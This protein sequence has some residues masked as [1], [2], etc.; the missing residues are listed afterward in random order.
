MRAMTMRRIIQ[1]CVLCAAGAVAGPNM[2]IGPGP[3]PSGW[4]GKPGTDANTVKLGWKFLDAFNPINAQLF[5]GWQFYPPGSP[6]AWT[7][8]QDYIL[9]ASGKPAQWQNTL[10][11]PQ[12]SDPSMPYTITYVWFSFVY[13]YNKYWANGPGQ[14][15]PIFS[16]V[17]GN[18]PNGSQAYATF[19]PY[20]YA[21]SYY[22]ANG[23][24]LSNTTQLDNAAYACFTQSLMISNDVL[25]SLRFYLG[26]DFYTQNGTV[27]RQGSI[28]QPYVQMLSSFQR[29]PIP[30]LKAK[31]QQQYVVTT[32]GTYTDVVTIAVSCGTFTN[33]AFR[34]TVN[35]SDP[36]LSSPQPYNSAGM[37][38]IDLTN[39]CTLKVRADLAGYA[40]SV[41]S[42]PFVLTVPPPI[43][44]PPSDLEFNVFPVNISCRDNNNNLFKPVSLYY[45]ADGSTPTPSS[46]AITNGQ[47]VMVTTNRVPLK[48][49]ATRPGWTSSDSRSEAYVLM[50]SNVVLNPNSGYFDTGTYINATCATA[51]ATIHYEVGVSPKTPTIS[52]P[53]AVNNKIFVSGSVVVKA[54]GFKS[55]WDEGPETV[56]YYIAGATYTYLASI[57]TPPP[58][59]RADASHP[60][61]LYSRDDG[62]TYLTNGYVIVGGVTN[63]NVTWTNFVTRGIY[64]YYTNVVVAMNPGKLQIDWWDGGTGIVSSLFVVQDG[65]PPGTRAKKLY[66]TEPPSRGPL[67]DVTRVPKLTFFY[68][69][70]I[71]A[72]SN[73]VNPETVW[74]DSSGAKQQL[75]ARSGMGYLVLLYEG[76]VTN[77]PLMGVDVVQVMPN[78]GWRESLVPVGSRMLPHQLVTNPGMPYVSAGINE[79]L[80]YQ[81]TIAGKMN[82][83]VFAIEQNPLAPLA[84]V[85]W[86]EMAGFGF[87]VN[88]PYEMHRYMAYWPD[89]NDKV[90]PA[91]LYVRGDSDDDLGP[92]VLIPDAFNA[93]LMAAEQYAGQYDHG[94]YST[95]TF[96]SSGPGKS[97]LRFAT[98]NGNGQA[99][100]EWVGFEVIKSVER[101]SMLWKYRRVLRLAP[102]TPR[103]N[104]QIRLVLSNNFSYA[105]CKPDGADVRFYDS[106]GGEL[107]YWIE[108]WQTGGV[109]IIWV[110]IADQGSGTVFLEY[111]NAGAMSL[112]SAA[113]TFDFYDNFQGTLDK[114]DVAGSPSLSNQEL[115]VHAG[116]ELIGE[117]PVAPGSII[118]TRIGGAAV[119]PVS[120]T[121]GSL[122]G[123]SSLFEA[124]VPFMS[125]MTPFVTNPVRFA[126]WDI[127]R[128]SS[129]NLAGIC[130]DGAYVSYGPTLGSAPSNT[131]LGV[132]VET[133]R[134]TWFRDGVQQGSAA[135]T[136]TPSGLL[137]PLINSYAAPASATFRIREVRT[138]KYEAA[139]PA[140]IIGPEEPAQTLPWNIG[141]ELRDEHQQSPGAGYLH[142]SQGNRYEP[143]I[144]AYP[145]SNSQIFAVNTG[146]LEVWWCSWILSNRNAQGISIP[147]YV[148]RYDNVW[149][150]LHTNHALYY[151]GVDDKVACGTGPAAILTNR[152]SLEAWIK[153]VGQNS[154]AAIIAKK[155][156]GSS[157]PGFAFYVNSFGT[158]DRRLV[159]ETQGQA[160]KT[161]NPVIVTGQWQ[162][163]AV[164][165]NGS[166]AA[167]YVNGI[168][169]P[170]SGSVNPAPAASAALTLGA[171]T[172]GGSLFKGGIDDV[173]VWD[174]A[175]SA[176]AIAADM[177]HELPSP[178]DDAGLVAYYP[179]NNGGGT[180]L[181]DESGFGNNGTISGALWTN[182]VAPIASAKGNL[183]QIIV[184]SSLGGKPYYTGWQ[185]NYIYVQNDSAQPG[186]NPNEEHA[187]LQGGVP[188]ALRND[189][190]RQNTSS[191]YTSEPFVL[192]PYRDPDKQNRWQLQV[193]QV[194]PTNAQYAFRY[195]GNHAAKKLAPPAPLSSWPGTRET[196]I[197]QGPGW[198]DRNNQIWARS[199]GAAGPTAQA[200]I[201]MQWYYPNIDQSWYIP[202][203]Y[204]P[205]LSNNNIPLLDR[206]AGTAGTPVPV[207]YDIA[208]E[209]GYPTLFVG[210]TLTEP[211]NNL[212]AIMHQTSVDIIYQQYQASALYGTGAA[213]RLIDPTRY[214]SSNLPADYSLPPNV[215]QKASNIQGLY[216]FNDLPP[217][218]NR[219]LWYDPNAHQLVYKGQYVTLT[220]SQIGQAGYLLLNVLSP[221]EL[222]LIT[223]TFAPYN[224]QNLSAAALQLCYNA[225]NIIEVTNNAIPFD[226]IALSAGEAQSTGYVTLAFNNSTNTLM[227]PPGSPV[228]LQVINIALPL[229]SGELEQPGMDQNPF[230]E[231]TTVRQTCDY[232]GHPEQFI[233]DWR[234]VDPDNN[235]QIPGN[236]T[237]I[238]NW[239]VYPGVSG[240][241]GQGANQV[242]IEGGDLFA[243]N[244]HYFAC[245]Y[246]RA[247]AGYPGGTNWSAWTPPAY[248]E[249]WVQRTLDAITPF[250]QRFTDFY[251]NS[252]NTLVNM[253]AQAG[254]RWDGMVPLDPQSIDQWGLIQ[255]YMTILKTAMNMSITGNPPVHDANANHT[256]MLAAGRL[257]DMYALLGNE[258]FADALDPT[259]GIGTSDGVYAAE[260]PSLY[261]FMNQT[262]SLLEETLCLLRGRG[263]GSPV[264]AETPPIQP[265]VW[266]TPYYNKL[267]WNFTKDITG[268]EVAYALNYDILDQN[269]NAD[270][271]MNEADAAMLYPQGH[272]DAWGH[273]L[274]AVKLY[275][276][277][278]HNPYFDWVPG[279]Y[280][281]NVGS[282]PV[283]VSYYHE[284]K[285]CDVA[286]A[287][288]RT[289]AEIVKDTYRASYTEDNAAIWQ[290]YY[291]GDT[292]RAWGV[293]E[294][295]VRAGMGAYFD[296]VIGN[297]VLPGSSSGT[298]IQKIDRTNTTELL[299]I[300]TALSDIQNV[301][302]NADRGLNPLGLARNV[303]PFDIDPSM[304]FNPDWTPQVSMSHFE[305][306]YDRAKGALANTRTVFNHARNATQEL[307]KQARSLNDFHAAVI[308]QEF[309]YTNRLIEIFGYPYPGDIGP[310]GAYP[311]GYKGPDLIHWMY[312]DDY[313]WAK[314]PQV[315]E[316]I[317]ITS[318]VYYLSGTSV[319]HSN[320]VIRFNVLADSQMA[321]RPST[322][323]TP[324]LAQGE[325]QRTY[326]ALLQA[327]GA[328]EA[329]VEE[330]DA[331]IDVLE[332]LVEDAKAKYDLRDGDFKYKQH[333]R[334]GISTINGIIMGAKLVKQGL[335]IGLSM[336][337]GVE[338]LVDKG[339]PMSIVAGLAVGADPSFLARL[340]ASAGYKISATILEIS[341]NVAEALE[342]VQEFL[343]ELMEIDVEINEAKTERDLGLKEDELEIERAARQLGVI[344]AEIMTLEAALDEAYGTY[345]AK[346]QEGYRVLEERLR[347]RQ[348][349]AGAIQNYR[350]QDMAFRIFRNDALQKYQAQFDLAARYAYLAAK[351][352][353][354]ETALQPQ[355]PRGAGQQYLESI[356]KTIA[357]GMVDD[358]GTPST[359]PARGD[360]GLADPLARM[361]MNWDYTLK[362]QLGFNNPQRE[363]SRFSLRSELFRCVPGSLNA[364]LNANAASITG[365]TWSATLQQCI[366]SNILEL[367]EFKRYCIPFSPRAAQEPGIVI[368]FATS[369]NAGKNYF[370]WDLAGGDH[371]YSSSRFATKIRSA[372]I[373]L[374]NY[375]NTQLSET[376]Y[377]Y[378][379]P[380]GADTL[381]SPGADGGKLRTWKIVDQALPVPF[382][383]ASRDLSNPAWIPLNDTFTEPI[384]AVRRFD[385]LRA[386]NDGGEFTTDQATY[387]SRL[388]GRS[389][390]NT[391]WLLIIPAIELHADRQ[392]GLQRFISTV[393]DIKIFFETYAYPGN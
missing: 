157:N 43:F 66:W 363:T 2:Q 368:R 121:R 286:A 17:M 259:I 324:R 317:V 196:I 274:M 237:N 268:G 122:C 323:T 199:A 228:S 185:N 218:L 378:L 53:V 180:L 338:D 10:A 236:M 113:F 61:Q 95:N 388:I 174:V 160:L 301:V 331:Q 153:P 351:A 384:C 241:S 103:S 159:F 146:T 172:D 71:P 155:N 313:Y 68:N 131:L 391:E 8:T 179:N 91:R 13:D 134:V 353:D 348:R 195:G 42:A 393:T 175:R 297:A 239:S 216:Y 183:G 305:Q 275:Y 23:N 46:T 165:F 14:R 115:F 187:T 82:G 111:G 6:P 290:G 184:A 309:D 96:Y 28:W 107:D 352:Y 369:I 171:F 173:R 129:L 203:W 48:A 217:H 364:G 272:G 133:G 100:S 92:V 80:V 76:A 243:L 109:S 21:E 49:L 69:E 65:P 147:S 347:F 154:A 282:V 279:T 327:R 261:C 105:H 64:L 318:A 150:T 126:D 50:V 316:T 89:E 206:F 5:S 294:W 278:V 376:P 190:N 97:L 381:R 248:I 260:A 222:I 300:A 283:N 128:N 41:A 233:F 366:V 31:V 197:A 345:S 101:S 59:A 346:L 312:L 281:E 135:T 74:V 152:F 204:V 227:Q 27:Y 299:L 45:T 232:S 34:Y 291:D 269:G 188:Y 390:W 12:S 44:A 339:T 344:L 234:Y 359:G 86:Q 256:I 213:V 11:V 104:F 335:T 330:F 84:E 257:A 354:Y 167:M 302:D 63:W 246:R 262:A 99:G 116:D 258:A 81:N 156:G 255:I 56:G 293:G 360:A 288:A 371:T 186:Y 319:N 16:T 166:N 57:M 194:V 143:S 382:P 271:V 36:T 284:Q 310:A 375:N 373:W 140:I 62:G 386:Y 54:K 87:N 73:V 245:R 3:D 35:G 24:R 25:S 374:V 110:E 39:S 93:Q 200:T 26:T 280:S 298:G 265:P 149:P 211:K 60:P 120:G 208:W 252:I 249:G 55:G 341:M 372:G 94:Y 328:L 370:G 334:D 125:D 311:S 158:G 367:P 67:V 230:D 303:V 130:A 182:D 267:V 19:T 273:Y 355:D 77:G 365:L 178:W 1:L 33:V 276:M 225:S 181:T 240:S 221:Q 296:W 47:N 114:W 15:N 138:R 102:P 79:N 136:H 295:A 254:K 176:S 119:T 244:S 332:M 223:N 112:S 349:T 132:A 315:T 117:R 215:L 333:W 210:D 145:Q 162:H 29:L 106:G 127:G 220:S 52:S 304:V 214:R 191:A 164:T 224:D 83:A 219:R 148:R 163:V 207:Y 342:T 266:T 198:R 137:Y 4:P 212:P 350:Y 123:V 88:W 306:V 142:V 124:D 9:P 22:D 30:T 226:S 247:K 201:G 177:Y 40:T 78:I 169:Q 231:Q 362:G 75:R 314:Q 72:P 32:G 38:L 326:A 307:R 361:K 70:G 139:P 292:N 337:K 379:I 18:R 118:E 229:F 285:F 161:T 389:V 329:K 356:V 108:Q 7:Y 383:I 308:Q 20:T 242:T 287:K 270:G 238:A 385:S 264:R 320:I 90:Q 250:E 357:L 392:Y 277:L 144:Y 343:K 321:V 340:A 192:M 235:G 85:F 151:D 209:P 98:D 322:W 336:A 289:G 253:V 168:A 325:V 205:S 37:L 202:T 377:F 193:Y 358:D 251:N 51:G 387:A 141:D 189:L 263:A 380:V 170:F 58:G